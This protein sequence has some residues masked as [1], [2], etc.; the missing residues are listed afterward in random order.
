MSEIGIRM[1][2][3]KRVR[4]D[5]GTLDY[6]P[7][8]TQ[9]KNPYEPLYRKK[10]RDI[11]PEPRKKSRSKQKKRIEITEKKD[12]FA[13]ILLTTQQKKDQSKEQLPVTDKEQV[14]DKDQTDQPKDPVG[15]QSFKRI[16][17]TN[18]D[19]D[20]KKGDLVL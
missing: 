9:R 13:N 10:E 5:L 4:Q 18:V 15:S 6:R 14:K 1:T 12:L 11:I 7:Y 8:Q 3:Y 19:P 16:R 2:R 20:K 17:V